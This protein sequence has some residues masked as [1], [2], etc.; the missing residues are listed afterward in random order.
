MSQLFTASR[1][2]AD[3]DRS[4]PDNYPPDEKADLDT[5]I[6]AA[7]LAVIKRDEDVRSGIRQITDNL[8]QHAGISLAVAGGI[9]LLALRPGRRRTPGQ[10]A[11]AS[12]VMARSLPLVFALETLWPKLPASLR[13]LVPPGIPEL[14]FGFVL[15]LFRRLFPGRKAET[16]SPEAAPRPSPVRSA[17]YV[18]LRRYLGRWY[19]IA[20]LPTPHEKRCVSD[21]TANY[22]VVGKRGPLS[23][24]NQCR[25]ANGRMRAVRGVARLVDGGS[26][27]RLEVSFAPRLLRWLPW[28]WSDYWILMVDADYRYAL[29]GTPDRRRL[30]L[31]SRTPSLAN[32]EHERLIACARAQGY[33]TAALRPTAHRK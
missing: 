18:D 15:P 29:V 33:D 6:H 7:E 10:P 9:L 12:S 17:K 16:G 3:A 4:V 28:V 11:M 1:P 8:R 30:W 31:L 23:V 13:K 24:F 21:V 20:R 25:L 5:R 14:L 2:R 19:E 32:E 26:N 22:G 27:A